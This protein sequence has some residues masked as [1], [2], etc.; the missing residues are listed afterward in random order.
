[1]NAKA[2]DRSIL[3]KGTHN[4]QDYTERE[5]EWENLNDAKGIPAE[6]T[7]KYKCF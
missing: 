6:I 5:L 2:M 3:L 4:K 7:S 1:M